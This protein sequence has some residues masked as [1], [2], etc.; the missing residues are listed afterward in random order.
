[1]NCMLG[2]LK[3]EKSELNLQNSEQQTRPTNNKSQST[4][5]RD[6]SQPF[7]SGETKD[8]KRTRENQH[9]QHHGVARIV[10]PLTWV[11]GH[12]DANCQ[13]GKRMIKLILNSRLI[14]VERSGCFKLC[15]QRMRAKSSKTNGQ[16]T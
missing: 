4:N 6:G 16:Q 5:R 1:M 2:V 12:E 14:S 13:Q 3:C 8:V 7:H 11:F 10:K 15:L 9:T